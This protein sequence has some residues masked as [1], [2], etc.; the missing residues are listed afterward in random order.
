MS[1]C[2]R[3][4]IKGCGACA[5]RESCRLP[6]NDH[7][8]RAQR[9]KALAIAYIVPFVLLAGVIAVTDALSDNEYVIG[10]VALAT[11]AVYYLTLFFIKPKV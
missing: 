9:W 11:V 2:E 1:E 3:D 8:S 5:L 10:G 4:D 7:Y 6:E